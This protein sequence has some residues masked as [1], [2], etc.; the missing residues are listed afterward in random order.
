MNQLEVITVSNVRCYLDEHGTAMLNVE[1]VARGLGFTRTEIKNG[2]EY[3]SILWHRVNKYLGEFNFRTDV[4][5]S[6]YIP[7]NVFY[8]LAMKANNETAKTFQSKVANEILPSIRKHGAYLTLEA[9]ERIL[10]N[11]DFIINLAQQVKDLQAERDALKPDAEYC[12]NVLKSTGTMPITLIAK[13]YGMSG[14]AMNKALVDAKLI[15][16]VGNTYVLNQPYAAMG[17]AETETLLTR[18]GV[19]KLLKWTEKGRHL[20]HKVLQD[21]C[22]TNRERVYANP[23]LF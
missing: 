12:R 23:E 17:Y 1:D 4:C 16:K 10:Y 7:E 18:G 15:R 22:S 3:T 20:I 9:A 14:V 19:R 8:L 21:K 13:E 11:P 5:E 2:K 6:D